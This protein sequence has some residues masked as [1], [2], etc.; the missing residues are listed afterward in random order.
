MQG[1]LAAYQHQRHLITALQVIKAQP[2]PAPHFPITAILCEWQ[3]RLTLEALAEAE[4]LPG[5]SSIYMT[6]HLRVTGCT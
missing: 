6:L 3:V 1:P 2:N 5:G 4:Y